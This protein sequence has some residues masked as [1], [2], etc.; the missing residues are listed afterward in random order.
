[1][2]HSLGLP[3]QL[4]RRG[5]SGCSF[6]KQILTQLIQSVS[7]TGTP[8]ECMGLSGLV[9]KSI[10]SMERQ[11]FMVLHDLHGDQQPLKRRLAADLPWLRRQPLELTST[12][13]INHAPPFVLVRIKT[14]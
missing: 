9:Q 7:R 8:G 12:Y 1:M 4:L 5:F 13:P 6:E 10:R 2:F 14:F 11:L 3:P